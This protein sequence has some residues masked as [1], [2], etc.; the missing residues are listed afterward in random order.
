MKVANRHFQQ[1]FSVGVAAAAILLL[2]SL[3]ELSPRV[4]SHGYVTNPLSRARKCFT[5]ANKHCGPATWDSMSFEGPKNFPA[6]G[7]PD[8]MIAGAD[9]YDEMDEAEPRRWSFHDYPITQREDGSYVVPVW[10]FLTAIH[11]TTKFALYFPKGEVNESKV[12]ERADFDMDNVCQDYSPRG[13][14]PAKQ[15]YGFYCV[16]PEKVL[17]PLLD[18]KIV[19]LSVWDVADTGNAFYQVIDTRLVL[20]DSFEKS[21]RRKTPNAI[22]NVLTPAN[23]KSSEKDVVTPKPRPATKPPTHKEETINL[24]KMTLPGYCENQEETVAIAHREHVPAVLVQVCENIL[25]AACQSGGDHNHHAGHENHETNTD[26]ED[27]DDEESTD[28]YG[29]LNY[30][31][32]N[33]YKTPCGYEVDLSACRRRQGLTINPCNCGTFISCAEKNFYIQPCPGKLF[34][35]ARSNNCEYEENVDLTKCIVHN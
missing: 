26:D 24:C 12:I 14:M 23:T 13:E 20:S 6:E 17:A 8:G 1:E 31:K 34:F 9:K 15:T 4:E 35:S 10:W 21:I 27:E 5:T 22:V 2:V 28:E 32:N 29:S 30:S 25:D 33:I 16:V 18:K 3:L 11:R 7:P 19:L